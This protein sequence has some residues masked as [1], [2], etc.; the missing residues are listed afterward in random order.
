MLKGLAAAAALAGVPVPPAARAR[1]ATPGPNRPNVVVIQVDDLDAGLLA[2][3]LPGLPAISGLV[4]GGASFGRYFVSTPLCSPSRVTL[5]RG[6]YAHNTGVLW[7]RGEEEGQG[8]FEAFHRLGLEENTLATWL[9]DGGYRTGLF[10]KYLNNYP[11]GAEPEYVPPGWDDWAVHVSDEREA[12]Y[13]DYTLNVNGEVVAFGSSPEDYSTDVIAGFAGQFVRDAAA[14]GQPFFLLATPYA[15]H[16]PSTFAPRH[17]DRFPDAAAPETASWNEEDVSDKPDWVRRL[18]PVGEADEAE[19][20]AGYRD[21]LRSLLAVDDLVAGLLAALDETG[22]RTST[23]LMFTSDNGFHFGEHRVKFGKV[24][25]YDESTRVPLV[26]AGPGVAAGASIGAI[27]GNVDLAPTIAEWAG[28]A[29]PAFVDGRSLAGLAAGADPETWRSWALLQQFEQIDERVR[30]T[31]VPKDKPPKRKPSRATATPTPAP[32]PTPA[33]PA[34][35]ARMIQA[36]LPP[37]A[38]LRGADVLYVE[39]ETGEREYYDLGS[40]PAALDNLAATADPRRME[41]LGA[42]LA[43]LVTCAA[44]QCREADAATA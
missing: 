14:A 43:S 8:G 3:A 23:Y 39:Y 4:A 12:F 31:P 26:I 37:F 29:V 33:A 6:Q 44:A 41:E 20:A 9:Q 30:A 38:A 17:A 2:T 40:D 19:I 25:P 34:A 42:A 18:P 22:Q 21:R 15:P 27:A 11:L 16:D 32:T 1:Q 36:D 35:P 28:V 7:N 5:L 24:T 10:G 13:F